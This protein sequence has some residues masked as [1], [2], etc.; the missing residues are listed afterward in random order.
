MSMTPNPFFFPL[1]IWSTHLTL[2]ISTP[3]VFSVA[4]QFHEV[5][6]MFPQEGIC[7]QTYLEITRLNKVKQRVFLK[8]Q[9]ISEHAH[10]NVHCESINSSKAKPSITDLTTK[11][12]FSYGHLIKLKT[13]RTKDGKLC[14]IRLNTILLSQMSESPLWPGVLHYC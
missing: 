9:E 7:G 6:I 1:Y 4:C 11:N 13:H 10:A 14:C 2:S 5:L 3:C 12:L 8:T